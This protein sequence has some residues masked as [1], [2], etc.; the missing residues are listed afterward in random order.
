MAK[1]DDN[2]LTDCPDRPTG[3]DLVGVLGGLEAL[4][5]TPS[6]SGRQTDP[7]A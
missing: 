3:R 4:V 2:D 6:L 7:V 5:L 1:N